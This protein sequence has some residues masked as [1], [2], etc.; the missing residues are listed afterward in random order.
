[1]WLVD[2]GVTW[3]VIGGW[4]SNYFYKN[5]VLHK[6]PN[7]RVVFRKDTDRATYNYVQRS[8]IYGTTSTQNPSLNPNL[9][10]LLTQA[11]FFERSHTTISVHHELW[12]RAFKRGQ[13]SDNSMN[14][15]HGRGCLLL[16]RP[17]W[18][19]TMMDIHLRVRSLASENSLKVI[20]PPSLLL[21]RD[22]SLSSVFV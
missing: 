16:T 22:P 7:A 11:Q 3:C 13:A 19:T 20:R 6:W 8:Q 2:D 14:G 10:A 21:L 15:L 9:S 1:M 5:K 4:W 18:M 17:L 12:V